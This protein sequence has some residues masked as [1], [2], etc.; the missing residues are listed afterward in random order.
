MTAHISGDTTYFS[1]GSETQAKSSL[2]PQWCVLRGKVAFSTLE[3]NKIK[4]QNYQAMR[5]SWLHCVFAQH[6]HRVLS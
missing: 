1:Q 5:R 6:T 3:E 4:E 2:G